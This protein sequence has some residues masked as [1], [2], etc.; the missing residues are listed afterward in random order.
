MGLA[1]ALAFASAAASDAPRPLP[2]DQVAWSKVPS[3]ADIASAQHVAAPQS[4][5]GDVTLRCTAGSVGELKD[6]QVRSETPQGLG[7]ASA[8]Q[9]L[10]GRFRATTDPV[11]GARRDVQIDLPIHF[12]GD[13]AASEAPSDLGWPRMPPL[14]LAQALFPE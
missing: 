1:L 10:T 14:E 11:P 2:A 12:T 5:V 9:R 8:A 3:A 13:A 6:C 4:S 7:L